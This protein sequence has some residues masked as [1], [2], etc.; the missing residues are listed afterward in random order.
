MTMKIF[1]IEPE[2]KRKLKLSFFMHFVLLLVLFLSP[3]SS[4]KRIPREGIYRVSLKSLPVGIA[5]EARSLPTE[6]TV[7]VSAPRDEKVVNIPEAKKES[8]A[9]KSTSRQGSPQQNRVKKT[10]SEKEK[11]KKGTLT[12]EEDIL[13]MINAARKELSTSASSQMQGGIEGESGIITGASLTGAAKEYYDSIEQKIK[14]EWVLPGAMAQEAKKL[15]TVIGVI[16]KRDGTIEKIWVEESSGN[17]YYDRAA[18]RAVK[19]ASPLPPI[20][21]QMPDKTLEIGIIF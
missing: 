13:A 14:N 18:L 21:A 1:G 7:P 10:V 20:P 16:I 8:L 17:I 12:T 19:K 2:L 9:R 5:G 3:Q 6:T 15:R 11:K 4:G